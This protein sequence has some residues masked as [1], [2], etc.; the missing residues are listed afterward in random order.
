MSFERPTLSALRDQART[1]IAARL[2]GV[3]P[4][5]RR[6]LARVLADA[7]AG[8][9]HHQYGYLDWIALQ[10]IP[11]TA[12]GAYLDRWARLVDL[13][14]TRATAAG[15]GCSVSWFMSGT[16]SQASSW[17]PASGRSLPSAAPAA[18]ASWRL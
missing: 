4:A 5:L 18:S 3:D 15:A 16:S 1:N 2:A 14:R 10:V 6:S 8:L 12:E 13:T 9:A 17:K 11:A 7:M